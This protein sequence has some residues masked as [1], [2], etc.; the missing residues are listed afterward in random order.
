M[1]GAPFGLIAE[2][3]QELFGLPPDRPR[4]QRRSGGL[5]VGRGRADE[6]PD[7]PAASIPAHPLA[8]DVDID[9]DVNGALD[10]D[11]HIS[12]REGLSERRRR[13]DRRH[14]R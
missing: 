14:E 3:G 8:V 11:G 12:C 6:V 5:V 7:D 9:V 1:Q 10:V 4:L 13:R 2:L